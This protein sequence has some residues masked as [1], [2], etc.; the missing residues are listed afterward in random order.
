MKGTLEAEGEMRRLVKLEIVT[1]SP[2][3][4]SCIKIMFCLYQN[5]QHVKVQT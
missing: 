5:L 1:V 3:A 4:N 2:I